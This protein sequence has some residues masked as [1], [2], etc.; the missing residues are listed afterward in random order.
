MKATTKK[1]RG[2]R[3]LRTGKSPASHSA[4]SEE[5]L[6]RAEQKQ[7]NP[8]WARHYR[9]LLELRGRLLQEKAE[10]AGE[11]LEETPTYSMSMADAATDEFDRDL[12]LSELAA[13]QDAIY[14]IDEAIHRIENNV[15]GNCEL[16]GKPIPQA[17]LNAVPWTRFCEDAEE[18]LE[19]QGAVG[20]PH[21]G[22][23][24]SAKGTVPAGFAATPEETETQEPRM[25]D[26]KKLEQEPAEER[27]ETEAGE[28]EENTS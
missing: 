24:A 9:R 5:L 22:Q 18:Q 21:L 12:A 15:Y 27:E 19:R 13:E 1:P 3:V 26:L 20:R 6:P 23:V 25:E 8:K 14:E 16:T 11:A 7:I 28:E 10:L 2:S 4:R 17:R